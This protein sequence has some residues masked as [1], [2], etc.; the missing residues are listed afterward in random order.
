MRVISRKRLLEFSDA[1]PAAVRPLVEWY[2]K[3]TAARWSS[4][5]QVKQTF[6]QTDQARVASGN[7]VAIFDIGGNK[8]RL[9]AAIHYKA[10]IVYVLRILTHRE[11]DRTTWKEQL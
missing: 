9:I 3:A 10:Q 4:F 5:P 7:T 8:F 11:C 2:A 1:H 6:A